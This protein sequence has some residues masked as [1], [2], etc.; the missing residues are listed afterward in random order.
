[1]MPVRLIALAWA[2]FL[3]PAGEKLSIEHFAERGGMSR[4]MLSSKAEGAVRVLVGGSIGAGSLEQEAFLADLFGSSGLDAIAVG[5]EDLSARGPDRRNL[6]SSKTPL[7]VRERE[8]RGPNARL[9]DGR[10]DARG[11]GR[12]HEGA[13]LCEGLR[14]GSGMD[15]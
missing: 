5:Y 10:R 13:R 6:L 14:N 8:G 1:M 11:A 3:G 4:A 9:P 12:R 2:A 15:D 7:R